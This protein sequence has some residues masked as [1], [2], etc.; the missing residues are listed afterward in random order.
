MKS[1]H[2]LEA[3]WS[4]KM[5]LFQGQVKVINFILIEEVLQ[6]FKEELFLSYGQS[7]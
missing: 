4:E 7:Y 6:A 3:H 2:T 1:L 5:Y